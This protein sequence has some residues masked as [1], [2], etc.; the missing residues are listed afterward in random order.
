M[1]TADIERTFTS[2]GLESKSARIAREAMALRAAEDSTITDEYDSMMN[3]LEESDEAVRLE[4][5]DFLL[6]LEPKIIALHAAAIAAK[7][8][9]CSQPECL[10]ALDILERLE[11]DVLAEHCVAVAC[12]LDDPDT[13]IRAKASRVLGKL[14]YDH[15]VYRLAKSPAI[16]AKAL[17]SRSPRDIEA[18]IE[19]A[20]RHQ[21]VALVRQLVGFLMNDDHER[22]ALPEQ[23]RC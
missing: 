4:A 15:I 1:S 9:L 17:S 13:R 5:M 11:H 8:S 23:R 7:L 6:M 2:S 10:R 12:K 18:A 20:K 19:L 22:K 3:K 21:D 14:R 16:I